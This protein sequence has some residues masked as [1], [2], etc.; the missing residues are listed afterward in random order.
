MASFHMSP[1]VYVAEY[2]L[3]TI[4]PSSA[5]TIGA[6]VGNF[7]WGPIEEIRLINDET[8]LIN[9][10]GKPDPINGFQWWLAANFLSYGNDLRVVRV[11]GSARTACA[12]PPSPNTLL[13]K[14]NADYDRQMLP[15]GLETFGAW[16]ARYAGA[17]AN[18]LEICICPSKEAFSQT[19]GGTSNPY[20]VATNGTMMTVT[21]TPAPTI[22]NYVAVGS[23]IVSP[24]GEEHQVVSIDTANQQIVLDEKFKY[25]ESDT[26]DLPAGT[27]VSVRWEFAD[28]FGLPPG[29]S[30]WA[31]ARRCRYDE[32]H[33]VVI[34]ATKRF[35]GVKNLVLE[36][37]AFVSKR[38]DAKTLNGEVNYY[39]DVINQ[40]SQYVRW[41]DHP[42]AGAANWGQNT[43][44][45][46]PG[47]MDYTAL[48]LPIRDVL[49]G[50]AD[51]WLV[52]STEQQALASVSALCAGY[53][54]F[55]SAEDLDVSLM[56]VGHESETV[57]SALA[58]YVI[59]LCE[60]RKDCIAIISPP[61]NQVVDNVGSQANDLVL[62]RNNSLPSTSYAVLDSNWKYQFDR[63]NQTYR[64]LPFC[65]DIAGLCARTDD[66]RNPW[67]S[68]A[69]FNRG[70]INNVIKVAWKPSLT[71]RDYLYSNGINPITTFPGQGTILYGDKT[72][73]SR[74]SA[75]DRINVRRLFIVIEKSIS[76]AARYT[77]FEF[78]DE[79]TRAQFRN[80]VEPFLK[81][82]QAD[83]GIFEFLVVCDDTNNTP[84][85]I[86][87]NEFVGDIYIK[88][89]RTINFI[90]LN[91]I[92]VATGVSFSEV[93]G[94][95]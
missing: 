28:A 54:L 92:A 32:M 9:Q 30:S 50:G 40:K 5:T 39:K 45:V 22:Q 86:D 73:L 35:S 44:G 1:G 88:P 49:S 57:M 90:Q 26:G 56:I 41:I 24:G 61:K 17:M 6:V 93:V 48:P 37:Y 70:I 11:A 7:A 91:F 8:M 82:V 12:T 33:V 2:D 55:R 64:W 29:T 84:D 59:Q 3:T 13:I 79:F 52:H 23:W 42:D 21:N 71:E 38:A 25:G 51:G 46:A 53:N 31:A 14:N 76:K 69:G 36:K 89:A 62:W 43:K 19:L 16:A 10:F 58:P 74:P 47:Y 81:H 63:Y 80:M 72:L 68:P 34:D 77:L 66:E 94:Q 78:N 85:V 20:E 18:G 15:G 65:A 60:E 4:V 87:R 75:F 95:F 67:W 27:H 83:R